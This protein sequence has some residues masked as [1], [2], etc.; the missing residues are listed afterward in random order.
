MAFTYVG[1]AVGTTS[2]TLPT[3]QTGDIIIGAVFR[4]GST[5][6]PT[7]PTAGGTVPSWSVNSSAGTACIQL[8]AQAQATS[9]GMTTGTW[10]NATRVEFHIYR[11]D[12]SYLTSIF[13]PGFT[14][15]SSTTLTYAAATKQAPNNGSLFLAFGNT[16]ATDATMT[17]PP[18]GFTLRNSLNAGGQQGSDLISPVGNYAGGTVSIGGTSSAWVTAVIEV[19]QYLEFFTQVA[20]GSDDCYDAAGVFTS[21][22]TTLSQGNNNAV[23][24]RIPGVTVPQGS[25]TYSGAAMFLTGSAL[26]SAYSLGAISGVAI[27]NAAAWSG[28]N[29]PATVTKTTANTTII[30]SF[31]FGSGPY[32]AGIQLQSV[33]NE[34]FARSGWTSGNAMAFVGDTAGTN[35]WNTIYSFEGSGANAP[36]VYFQYVGGSVINGGTR[37]GAAAI[38]EGD[39]TV[40]STGALQIK[41]ALAVT[42]ANDTVASTGVLPIKAALAVTE[43]NDTVQATQ[44]ATPISGALAVTEANDTIVSTGALLV[45]GTLAVTEAND[46]IVATAV[47]PITAN[48]AITEANDTISSN[49]YR[50]IDGTASITEA[51][52][53][54]SSTIFPDVQVLATGSSVE[55]QEG[56]V[57]LVYGWAQLATGSA[58]TARVGM[59]IPVSWVPTPVPTAVWVPTLD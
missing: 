26:P 12:P 48:A 56:V 25:Q 47:L 35:T 21:G 54:M 10:T 11:P 55:V 19:Y 15:G 43:Q 29:H 17:S 30:S 16:R 45:Q 18:S 8:I 57:S 37:V 46:T 23:G 27:D 31:F 28:S 24:V 33:L 58:V 59:V 1:S 52:D 6:A 34:I 42:E 39:D 22:T 53:T 44:S 3:H 41:A 2:A 20:T 32:Q 13:A 51:D 7:T 9:A 4:S 50:E 38:T 49:G 14:T 5:T 36:Y 40:A